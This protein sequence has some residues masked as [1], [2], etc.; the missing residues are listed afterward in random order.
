M[1]LS[2]KAEL[3]LEKLKKRG[4]V[5]GLD[6]M[7]TLMQAIDD[8]QE[9]LPILHIAGTNG[10][11]SCC[12]MLASILSKQGYRV[13]VYT[14]PAV[15]SYEEHFC[16]DGNPIEEE[17]LSSYLMRLSDVCDC[18]EKKNL[19]PTSFEVETALSY[20][21]FK[22]SS[23]D[24]CI[25]EVG[26][27]GALDATNVM[28]HS[29]LSIFTSI[30]RDHMQ[31]LGDNMADIAF[32]KAGILKEGGVAVSAPQEEEVRTVLT[33]ETC[34]KKAELTFADPSELRI[35]REQPPTI[36]YR[37]FT[38]IPLALS[39]TYQR[40]NA[41]VVLETVRVLRRL[42][43]EISDAS[44]VGGMC[45][46]RWPG[47]MECLRKKPFFY[48]DG[49]H[50]LPAARCLLETIALYFTNKTITYIIGVLADKEHMAMM[51]LLAPRAKTIITLTPHNPRA[52]AA[53]QL[54]DEIKTLGY[55]AVAASSYEEAVTL[56][57]AVKTDVILAF[58]SL[59]YLG[60]L[61]KIVM[62][63]NHV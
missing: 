60:E 41:I 51:E 4:S 13:G 38:E 42:G 19:Y 2:E 47:R 43:V 5:L 12:A 28:T 44:V 21:Y 57:Y 56:A 31:Y 46:A 29:L 33:E 7:R 50:N 17:V 32:Q 10:K 30:G 14:S 45:E 53:E 22:E 24:F 16:V 37:E 61:R 8:P 36:S 23:C 59:S 6:T 1:A 62:G 35:D 55:A 15:F 9:K 27:G 18:L 20:L 39:G 3:F 26:M 11:G 40:T 52:L 48:I 34:R 49:A 58:G 63:E 54:A 25:M